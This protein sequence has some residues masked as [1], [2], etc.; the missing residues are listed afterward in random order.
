MLW[1]ASPDGVRVSSFFFWFWQGLGTFRQF[2][3]NVVLVDQNQRGPRKDWKK[4]RPPL[5]QGAGKDGSRTKQA[6]VVVESPAKAKTIEKYLGSGYTVV[7]SYGH[8]RDLAARAGSVRP[9]DDYTM[10]WEVPAT[11]RP[12]INS[13]KAAVKGY[14]LFMSENPALE[15][16]LV[17]VQSHWNCLLN[18]RMIELCRFHF[19]SISKSLYT[20][21]PGVFHNDCRF[22]ACLYLLVL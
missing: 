9:D 7:A 20:F 11:A 3:A 5:P 22:F 18:Q 15:S 16:C 13:I 1:Q 17:L 8:V 10:L 4:R 19:F 12:H 6:V 2:S 21:L 14:V